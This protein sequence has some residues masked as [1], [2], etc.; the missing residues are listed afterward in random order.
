MK[1]TTK[2]IL[3]L[4]ETEGNDT[5]AIKDLLARGIP[6]TNFIKLKHFNNKQ[7]NDILYSGGGDFYVPNGALRLPEEWKTLNGKTPFHAKALWWLAWLG[8]TSIE[9]S[10]I[11]DILEKMFTTLESKFISKDVELL[12]LII[13]LCNW[14]IRES[15]CLAIFYC[16]SKGDAQATFRIWSKFCWIMG[17]MLL[18]LNNIRIADKIFR[19]AILNRFKSK[20]KLVHKMISDYFEKQPSTFASSNGLTS[21]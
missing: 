11:S 14:G 18:Y 9:S 16:E 15:D 8:H 1:I 2:I 21:M 20:K 12:L 3:T 6:S 10:N 4:T 5:W 13:S 17:P 19:D 7:W